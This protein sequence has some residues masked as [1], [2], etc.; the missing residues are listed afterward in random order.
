MV[1][2]GLFDHLE[3][4]LVSQTGVTLSIEGIS[5][6]NGE[7]NIIC[8]A[9]SAFLSRTGLSP[10]VSIKLTKNIPVSAGLGG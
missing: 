4:L 3:L 7:D 8:R 1:P 5:L 10:G 6:P 2:V 9:A